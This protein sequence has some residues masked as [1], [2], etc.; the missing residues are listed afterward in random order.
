MI[1][2]HI[3]DLNISHVNHT[4][5]DEVICLLHDEFR[6]AGPLTMNKGWLHDYLGMILDFPIPEKV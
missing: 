4:A 5:V 3:D 6:Q 1:I 2:W